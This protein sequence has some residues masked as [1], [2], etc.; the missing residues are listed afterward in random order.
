ME[1]YPKL[2]GL[3]SCGIPFDKVKRI[4]MTHTHLDHIGCLPEILKAI[5]E[6]EVWVHKDEADYLER[7]DARIVWGNQMFESMIRSQYNIPKDL[8]RISPQKARRQGESRPRR[9]AFRDHL[10]GHSAG[11]SAS[12][13]MN[14]GS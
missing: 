2:E 9:I 14:T 6:A 13:I 8:F 5:P 4:I 7:G 3:E 10:P 12:S 1:M 11:A